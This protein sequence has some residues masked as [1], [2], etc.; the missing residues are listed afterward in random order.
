[1]DCHIH[2]ARCGHGQGAVADY[3]LAAR[4]AGVGILAFT[5]HL[6]LPDDFPRARDYSMSAEE[7]PA[8]VDEVSVAARGT[9]DIRVLLGF[10]VDWMSSQV[11]LLECVL[12]A[13]HVDVVLGSVHMID[14]WAF[15]D[16]DLLDSWEGRV[17]DAV[18]ERYFADISAAARSGIFDVMA[19]PDLVKK[20]CHVPAAA[21]V[22]LYDQAAEAFAEGGVAVEVSSAGLRKPCAEIYPAKEFLEACFVRGVPVTIGSDAHQPLEVGHGFEAVRDVLLSVGYREA[23]YFEGRQMREVAL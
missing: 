2:T 13:F 14:G 11:A 18:W 17:V 9:E 15:D 7:I 5:E 6:P 20:F 22:A 23:V 12:E 4:V 19:H 1:M 21:P 8:Y 3:V 16:P 10:E